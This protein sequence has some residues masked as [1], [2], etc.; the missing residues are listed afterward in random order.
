MF[1]RFFPATQAALPSNNW[2]GRRRLALVVKSNENKSKS[3]FALSY[4]C[5]R[6]TNKSRSSPT[7]KQLY[8]L[9]FVFSS[10]RFF[11]SSC[12]ARVELHSRGRHTP[13]QPVGAL[14]ASLWET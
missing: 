9:Y 14:A 3:Q 6:W 4:S 10:E 8:L 13:Q 1:I 12:T 5:S 11:L 2:F 7:T